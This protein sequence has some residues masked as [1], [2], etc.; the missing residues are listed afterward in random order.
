MLE[1]NNTRTAVDHECRRLYTIKAFGAMNDVYGC[2][3]RTAVPNLLAVGAG[4]LGQHHSA[5]ERS[6]FCRLN[7][8][9]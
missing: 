3:S 5:D 2:N 9:S 6:T 1:R 4:G 7:L 8:T